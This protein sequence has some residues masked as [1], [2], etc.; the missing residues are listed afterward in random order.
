MATKILVTGRSGT[1]KT[2]CLRDLDPKE[3]F[4]I[5]PDEKNPPFQGWRKN[6]TMVDKDSGKFNANTC[7]FYKTTD[8]TLI[9]KSLE[10]ISNN[11]PEIKVAVID[12][13]TYAMIGEFMNKA[14]ITGLKL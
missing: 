6:Y 11:R 1:G 8:W 10:F 14:K 12:T 9:Q 5:C 2:Y 4:I 7:N 13:I 3:T